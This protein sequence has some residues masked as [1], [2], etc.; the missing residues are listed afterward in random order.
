MVRLP[1][2]GAVEDVEM[3]AARQSE[4]NR[5]PP[6]AIEDRAQMAPQGD[7]TDDEERDEEQHILTDA[8]EIGQRAGTGAWGA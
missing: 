4:Q 1:G 6:L 5:L 7:S 2:D 8:D 3:G